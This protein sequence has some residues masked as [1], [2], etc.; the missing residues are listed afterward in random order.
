M[1][2]ILIQDSEIAL[3]L[4][5]KDSSLEKSTS[6]KIEGFQMFLFDM[7]TSLIVKSVSFSEL[8]CFTFVFKNLERL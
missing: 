6:N 4:L 1:S 3:F 5:K 2:L 7:L 8:T